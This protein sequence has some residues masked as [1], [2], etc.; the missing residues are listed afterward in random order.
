ME[1]LNQRRAKEEILSKLRMMNLRAGQH[2][3]MVLIFE[4]IYVE[5]NPGD[6]RIKFGGHENHCTVIGTETHVVLDYE[7]I[8][9]CSHRLKPRISS[10]PSTSLP[11]MASDTYILNLFF[12]DIKHKK[13][14]SLPDSM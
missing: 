11:S 5:E 14:T 8:F 13:W 4:P 2:T 10:T 7:I 3:S 6:D 12:F 1:H 9:E